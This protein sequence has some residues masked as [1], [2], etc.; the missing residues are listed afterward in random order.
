MPEIAVFLGLVG[1]V[2]VP[3]VGFG[4]LLAPRL[5]RSLDRTADE[6]ETD[7]R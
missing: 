2:V 1:L 3:G 7:P 6:E 5:E 4:M